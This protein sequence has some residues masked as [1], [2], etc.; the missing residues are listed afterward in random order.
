MES[1][2]DFPIFQD[3]HEVEAWALHG[4]DKDDFIIYGADH[5][6]HTFVEFTDGLSDLST[7]EGYANVKSMVLDAL[8]ATP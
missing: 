7:P 3:T 1:K 4:G 5:T 6:V 2:T 8:G